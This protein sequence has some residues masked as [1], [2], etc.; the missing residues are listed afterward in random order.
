MLSILISLMNIYLYIYTTRNKSLRGKLEVFASANIQVAAVLHLIQRRLGNVYQRF[1][2]TNCACLRL[3][4]G[5][6]MR[7]IYIY[8]IYY[9]ML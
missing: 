9:V 6:V 8:Y 5:S 2:L 1:I 4:E 7:V 3:N